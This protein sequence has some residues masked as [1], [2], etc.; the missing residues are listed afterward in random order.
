MFI[1]VQCTF[2]SMKCPVHLSFITETVR[3]TVSFI[4]ETVRNTALSR[5]RDRMVFLFASE[6]DTERACDGTVLQKIKEARN[7]KC[8]QH[9]T[10]RV[11]I[12]RDDLLAVACA[13]CLQEGQMFW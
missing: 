8:M 9:T 1:R 11:L 13:N 3:N 2:M 12:T 6:P 7:P 4:T 10:G 5:I